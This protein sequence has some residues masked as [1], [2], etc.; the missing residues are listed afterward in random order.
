MS[1]YQKALNNILVYPLKEEC[2]KRPCCQCEIPCDFYKQKEKDYDILKK[3][4][5]KATPKKVKVTTIDIKYGSYQCDCPV[6]G[7][8]LSV[9]CKP[10]EINYCDDCGQ[11]LDWS[12]NND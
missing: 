8:F 7:R 10:T 1:K 12:D 11:A 6:C 5:D 2:S 3:L 9:N 4:V